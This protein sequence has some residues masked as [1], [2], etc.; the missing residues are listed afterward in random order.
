MPDESLLRYT[1]HFRVAYHQT[2][3][4]RRVH[5]SNYLNFFE[6]SRVEMLRA[7]GLSYKQIED[8]GRLLVV[9]E[10]NVQYFVAAEFDDQLRV[11]VELTEVRKVRLRHLYHVLRDDTL[12]ARGESVIACVGPEGRPKRL[13]SEFLAFADQTMTAKSKV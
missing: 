13:P 2:D 12:I 6:D 8:S 10:M 5:H 1:Y 4:Q 3:G 9:T 7:G 11:E